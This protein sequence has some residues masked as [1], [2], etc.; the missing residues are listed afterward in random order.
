MKQ[1]AVLGMPNTCKSTLFN[2]MTGA[3]ANIGNWPGIT[4]D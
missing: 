4:V 1:I 3:N 2:R